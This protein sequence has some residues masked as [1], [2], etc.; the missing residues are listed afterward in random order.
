MHSLREFQA[1]MA[2]HLLGSAPDAGD[3]LFAPGPIGAEEGLAIYRANIEAATANALRLT[4]PTVDCV[5]GKAYFNHL[6]TLRLRHDPPRSACLSAYAKGFPRFI[7]ESAPA[8]GLPYLADVASFDLALAGVANADVHGPSRR[9]QLD[10]RTSLELNATLQVLRLEFP[11]DEI[12]SAIE[13][14][15][16]ALAEIDMRPRARWLALWRSADGVRVRGI[17]SASGEFLTAIMAGNDL[18]EALNQAWAQSPEAA[19]DIDQQI[20]H[21]PFARILIEASP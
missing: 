7:S 13:A 14:D 21:A 17:S 10:G 15:E 8:H 9:T 5:V 19:A 16:A 3:G 6:C 18:A 2:S 12:R 20:I 4:Y 11:A 1:R